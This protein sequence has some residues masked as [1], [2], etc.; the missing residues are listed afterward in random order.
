MRR[1]SNIRPTRVAK[2][3]GIIVNA[4]LAGE[5]REPN[6]YGATSR[7]TATAVHPIP[8]DGGQVVIIETPYD[9]DIIILQK[10]INAP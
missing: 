10:Q 8:Q 6:G 4:V 7:R 3:K 2:Q 9:G 1:T 5:A